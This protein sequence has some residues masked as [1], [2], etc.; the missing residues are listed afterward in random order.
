MIDGD[1]GIT[2]N[3]VVVKKTDFEVFQALDVDGI[4]ENGNEKS[5]QFFFRLRADKKHCLSVIFK[6]CLKKKK[7]TPFHFVLFNIEV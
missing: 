4:G 7:I 6:I 2:N 3:K 5:N 1:P